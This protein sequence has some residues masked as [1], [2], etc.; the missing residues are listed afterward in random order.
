M[1]AGNSPI[2]EFLSGYEVI[3]NN[4]I[5][6]FASTGPRK[7]F[8]PFRSMNASNCSWHIL[9]ERVEREREGGIAQCDELAASP[10]KTPLMVYV[11]VMPLLPHTEFR[12]LLSC[13]V[14]YP[15]DTYSVSNLF[16]EHSPVRH[17]KYILSLEGL[18]FVILPQS[19]KPLSAQR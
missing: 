3:F 8:A 16:S 10:D 14:L 13:L 5:K 6:T 17:D 4:L 2:T 11:D 19:P 18:F 9:E 1:E 7:G 12:S 15:S